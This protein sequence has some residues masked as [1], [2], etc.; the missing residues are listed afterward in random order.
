MPSTTSAEASL[1]VTVAPSSTISI[2]ELFSLVELADRLGY[3]SFWLPETWGADA[4]SL[5]A[6]LAARTREI[7]LASGVFNVYSRSAALLAQTAA[8]LQ[9]LSSGR[10][11]L[12][13]G[14]SGP[15]VI[16]RW[17]AVPYDRPVERTG[18][19]IEVIRMALSGRRVDYEGR[20]LAMSDFRLSLVP[21][22][23]V[24]IYVAAL[25]PRNMRMTGGLADGWLPIFAARG[26]MRALRSEL[27]AGAHEAGRDPGEIATAAYIPY[28][29]GSRAER[30]L[31]QQIAYY[32]G[33]MGTFYAEFV[34]RLG[35]A[36]QAAAIREPWTAG[37]R[38]G[39]VR[40][41]APELL[42]LC[43]LGS[44]PDEAH[45][46]LAQYRSE[47]IQVPILALPTGCTPEE[48][49]ETLLSLAPRRPT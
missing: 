1:G 3:H 11:I 39:A 43:T 8:T 20:I 32:V 42:E 18:E 15:G 13:L 25:G 19:Y 38:A 7:F 47:G 41:V 6:A 45:N 27:E 29:L 48:A 28:L 5:L 24:P 37:D 4:A 14:A 16:E 40:A 33:G 10:F 36:S 21:E 30:L 44:Q 23:P 26:H 22:G 12:G 9:H 49:R 34:A 35:M 2:A 17:H 46:R 31:R